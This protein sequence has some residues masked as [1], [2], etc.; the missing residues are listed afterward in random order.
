MARQENNM[1]QIETFS[2]TF[3]CMAM[4]SL[5]KDGRNLLLIMPIT[6]YRQFH[7]NTYR[8]QNQ[9]YLKHLNIIYEILMLII[10][11]NYKL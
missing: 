6:E 8:V 4:D 10:R 3:R 11:I 9:A 1:Q 2:S 5:W 7:L